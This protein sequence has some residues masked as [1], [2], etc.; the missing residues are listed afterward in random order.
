VKEYHKIQTVYLRD[1]ATNFKALLEGHWALPEFEYLRECPWEF[2][3]KVDGTNIRV[4]WHGADPHFAGK[5]D[6][7]Q[8][9]PH[10]LRALADTFTKDMLAAAFP[11]E[12]TNVCL[13]G[14]GY[15][16]KIQKGGGRYIPNGCAFIL[17]DVKV[18]DWWLE[19]KAVFD[20]AA[21]LGIQCV[22]VVAVGPLREGIELARKGFKSSV[23]ADATLDAEGLVMRPAVQLWNRK[24]E[25]VIA[26][27]KTRDFIAVPPLSPRPDAKD[28]V[29]P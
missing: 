21:K 2:T 27:I 10:L 19:R 29:K 3:E 24:G 7:A 14:E 17:F 26:K 1:P 18:G 5:T 16:A 13:Y 4:M 25:R 28:P 22:P 8:I 11:T 12:T 15:G 9:S 20:V 6:D 23:S